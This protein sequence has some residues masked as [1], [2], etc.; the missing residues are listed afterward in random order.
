MISTRFVFCCSIAAFISLFFLNPLAE[1]DGVLD[2][3]EE[4]DDGNNSGEESR[5][6]E[7]EDVPAEN[8]MAAVRHA[9]A[10]PVWG[11]FSG[12]VQHRSP[13][14]RIST[15]LQ[16]RLQME[17]PEFIRV[18]LWLH[19]RQSVYNMTW[20]NSRN[21]I[22]SEPVVEVETKV[23]EPD[24]TLAELGM[25]IQDLSFT[26]LYWPVVKEEAVENVRGR[27]AR[28]FILENPDTEKRMRIWIWAE[29]LAPVKF[30]WL[31]EDGESVERTLEV[32]AFE[33]RRGVWYFKSFVISKGEGW[34]TRVLFS[35]AS[36]YDS[37]RTEPPSDLFED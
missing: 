35:D 14:A 28:V 22:L 25:R 37:E 8:F 5:A 3:S 30:Q 2:F 24:V 27:Q 33:S 9:F 4:P 6:I 19:R 26:F 18:K 20:E 23:E 36:L 31:K 7:W 12:R 29:H 10:S 13:R 21:L 34:G 16:V 1:A 17:P 11:E 32:S 15:D